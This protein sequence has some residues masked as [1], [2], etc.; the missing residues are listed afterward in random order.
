MTGRGNNADMANTPDR[1]AECADEATSCG[2]AILA[3]VSDDAVTPA[4]LAALRTTG[5]DLLRLGKLLERIA[6]GAHLIAQIWRLGL[7]KA[8]NEQLLRHIKHIGQLARLPK[9]EETH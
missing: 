6:V 4:E 5:H 9:K 2:L 8:P 3:T 7:D 1:V